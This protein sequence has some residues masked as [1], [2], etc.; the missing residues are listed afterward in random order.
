VSSPSEI[1]APYGSAS[2]MALVRDFDRDAA[3]HR[4]LIREILQTQRESFY[5]AAIEI[6]KGD[7]DSRAVQFLVALLVSANLLFRALCDP[8]LDR[9]QATALARRAIRVEPQVDAV[10]AR[11]LVDACMANPGADGSNVAERLMEILGEISDGPRILPSLMRILRNDNPYL[12]S[13]AVLMIGR[14]NHSLKWVKRR[15]ADTDSRVRANA[16]E[17][18]WGMDT[19]AARELLDLASRDSSNRVAG[20]A[21]LG[22]YLIGD[23]STVCELAKM[24]GHPYAAFRRTAA[25]VMGE[26]GDPRFSEILG[27]M[28]A[29]SHAEVRKNAFTAVGQIRAAVTEV[30]RAGEWRVAGFS[31]S[32]DS[33]ASQ[34]RIEVAVV[35]ADGRENPRVLPVQFILSENGQL[36]WSYRVVERPVP[37]AISVIF[38]FPRSAEPGGKPWARGAPRC[39][40]W[41]RPTDLWCAVPYSEDDTPSAGVE[42]EIPRFIAS[43]ESAAGVFEPTPKRIDRTGFWKAI[44]RSVQPGGVPVHGKRHLIVLAPA[45]VGDTLEDGLVAAVHASRTAVEVVSTVPNAALQAFCHRTNGHFHLVQGGQSIEDGISLAYL[46]LLARYEIRYQPVCP[47]AAGLKLRVHAP[48]GWGEATVPF[49]A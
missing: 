15:L 28:L 35:T 24:A 21:L 49:P 2:L 43:A 48:A 4:R 5:A 44:E 36:V 47:D 19:A 10:L 16:V 25:W 38:L 7:T 8:A 32:R 34:R 17:A 23:S 46:N 18:M 31:G 6:L 9:R 42:L 12:R 45:E 20:N 37:E 33:P 3:T 40:T 13:K 29:D 30:S 41:K 22:Q 26:T 39:L 11:Q 27:R 14:G 1:A